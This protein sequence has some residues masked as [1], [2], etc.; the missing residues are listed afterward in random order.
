MNLSSL[1]IVTFGDAESL[2]EMLWENALQHDLFA[3]LMAQST[4]PV[5]PYGPP[6]YPL[7]E[8]DPDNLDDWLQVHYL[9][10]RAEDELLGLETPVNMLDTDWNKETDFYDWVNYHANAHAQRVAYFS[11]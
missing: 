9:V 6:R 7:A 11:L 10:H 4:N 5:F 3:K 2:K 1:T 8:A